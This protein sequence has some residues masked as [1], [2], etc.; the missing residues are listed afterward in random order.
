MLSHINVG[1]GI[2]CTIKEVAQIIAD[3]TKFKGDILWDTS[4]P[5]GTY[6]KLMDV[7]RLKKLGWTSKIPLEEGLKSTYSWF[8]Q[9][10]K[11]IRR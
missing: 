5:D 3:I 1:S 2:D 10:Q 9:N 7:S 11:N 8:L 6:K 4:M